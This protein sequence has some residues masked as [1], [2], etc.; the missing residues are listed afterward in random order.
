MEKAFSFIAE[1]L[2][3][4]S[5]G[6]KIAGLV[7]SLVCVVVLLALAIYLFPSIGSIILIIFAVC[8]MMGKIGEIKHLYGEVMDAFVDA[9]EKDKYAKTL[10]YNPA[11]TADLQSNPKSA[12]SSDWRKRNVASGRN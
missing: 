4:D 6:Q 9:V 5:F 3:F 2:G 7:G 1:K 12:Q 10:K 11:G 8:G